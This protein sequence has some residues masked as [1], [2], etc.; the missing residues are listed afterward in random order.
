MLTRNTSDARRVSESD[1]LN[2][3]RSHRR[4]ASPPDVSQLRNF[5]LCLV[6]DGST[7]KIMLRSGDDLYEV[8]VT[9]VV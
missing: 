3:P 9:K 2:Q 8:Q 5:E 6:D 1:T 7:V 4:F